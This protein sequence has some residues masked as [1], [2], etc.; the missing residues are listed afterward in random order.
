MLQQ[1]AHREDDREERGHAEREECP[2]K[3]EGSAGLG[4][5]SADSRPLHVDE[6]DDQ[7][8]ERPKEDDDVPWSPF[9]QHQRSVT[10]GRSERF[11]D[12]PMAP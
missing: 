3:E 9:G 10:A 8:K 6:G 5:G 11:T 4:D 12:R 1:S 7:P 2:D